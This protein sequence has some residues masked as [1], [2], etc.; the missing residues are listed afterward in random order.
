M[1]LYEGGMKVTCAGKL[2]GHAFALY[3]TGNCR[4]LADGHKHPQYHM[5]GAQ[6]N[7]NI[8]QSACDR[9]AERFQVRRRYAAMLL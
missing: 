5:P 4:A 7:L 2:S 3:F 6:D 1:S 9:G 8:I